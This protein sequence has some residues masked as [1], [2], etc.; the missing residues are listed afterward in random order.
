MVS[1]TLTGQSWRIRYSKDIQSTGTNFTVAGYRYSTK[2]Y[3]ALEDVLDTYSDN[4]HYDHVRNRTDLSLSQDII[5][6]SISLTLY[7]E[8]Y[9][10]DTHTTSL[11]IGYNNT[12]HNVSYGINYSYTLNADNSQ[13]E[14]DDTEDSNDQQISINIS[15]PLDAFMPSTYATYNMNSAK[16]DDTTHTVGLN[17]TA[18]AQKNLSWSV[19]EG[20]SSQEKA[21]S[22]NVSATYNG[23]YADINGGYSYDNHMRRLNYGVQG[24]VLLHRNGLTL[25]QPMDDTIILVKAPGAAGVPV[26]NETGVDTD[27]RGY[28]VVPY[29]SPYHRNEVSLDTTGIRKNIELIDTSKTLVPTRGAVVRAEYKTNI[30]YK[31][32]MVLTRINNLP[33]PFGATVSSLTKPDNHSSFVGDAGQT[34]LTGLEKQGRLLVKW[35]PTAADRCQVSYRIPSSPSASGVEILHEQ[36]Q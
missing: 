6:G 33:V 5:Y 1:D 3:Y 29:A 10:N 30:G 2:D 26:N 32:L 34:W 15:I 9:W 21:T 13:D 19:Q 31:A 28:A 8:D 24:G 25:S 14:D 18:L 17:G 4:S 20:Y 16:D 11:G 12:W 23:T 7:N 36:C 22:G 35:G 27:F